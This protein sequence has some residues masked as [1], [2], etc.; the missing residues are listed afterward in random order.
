MQFVVYPAVCPVE[1]ERVVENHVQ[2]GCAGGYGSVGL[3]VQV[4]VV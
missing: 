3:A 4:A 1:Q 2:L